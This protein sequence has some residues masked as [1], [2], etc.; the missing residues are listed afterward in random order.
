MKSPSDRPATLAREL[1]ARASELEQALEHAVGEGLDQTLEAAEASIAR[2]FGAGALAFVRWS[3][4]ALVV[5]MVVGFFGF[6]LA[7]HVN[8]GAKGDSS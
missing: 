5:A 7:K 2:R 8:A 4:R 1:S 3:M 6:G